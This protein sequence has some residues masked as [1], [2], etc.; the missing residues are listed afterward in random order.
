MTDPLALLAEA[1]AA[2]ARDVLALLE[3]TLGDAVRAVVLHGSAV[4]G[5]LRP[6]SDLDLL[7]VT[8][9]R[10]TSDERRTLIDVLLVCS[11]SRTR[12]DLARHLEVTV[13]VHADIQPWHYPPPLELQYGD[14]W[15]AEFEAGESSPWRSPDPDLA[16]VLAAARADGRSLVGPPPAEL[17]DPVPRA[18]LEH[19]LRAVIPALL[20]DFADDTRN[21]L[22]TLARIALT[23]ETGAIEP[24]DVAAAHAAVWLSPISAEV[25]VRARRGYEGSTPDPWDGP[26]AQTDARVAADEL[27]ARIDALG[28]IPR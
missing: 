22:L 28:S 4:R 13:V 11:R 9:R 25:L 15:R 2:Q 12:P 17:F 21:V 23:L 14:W 5:G 19:A 6:D 24:K 8:A 7:V 3:T 1:D 27:L 16:I 10:L 26:A 20:E 18:D